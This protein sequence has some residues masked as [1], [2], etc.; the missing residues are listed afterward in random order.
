M[1]WSF[2]TAS[3]DAAGESSGTLIAFLRDIH[4]QPWLD[5]FAVLAVHVLA[6]LVIRCVIR[7]H[8]I[9]KNNR[10]SQFPAVRRFESKRTLG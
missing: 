6:S 3:Y 2:T 4:P 8:F 1:D 10:L 9:E 7:A 5:V